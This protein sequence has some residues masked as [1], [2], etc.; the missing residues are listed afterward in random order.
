MVSG[1]YCFEKEKDTLE[2]PIKTGKVQAVMNINI[3]KTQSMSIHATCTNNNTMCNNSPIKEVDK[4]TY[5]RSMVTIAGG[6]DVGILQWIPKARVYSLD[7]RK[8]VNQRSRTRKVSR[9]SLTATWSQFS[10]LEKPVLTLGILGNHKS[11]R[12]QT[13]DFHLLYRSEDL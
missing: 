11:N 4:F 3:S 10:Y 8:F 9:G 12:M 1:N 5:M 6:R 2:E 13:G 7:S